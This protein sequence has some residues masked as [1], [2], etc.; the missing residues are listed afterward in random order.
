M[1][2]TSADG[3]DVA[4]IES[5]GLSLAALGG[6]LTHAYPPAFQ[7]RLL[8]ASQTH[9]P[10][11]T[12]EAD[13]TN[14]HIN[15]VEIFLQERGIAASSLDVVG[16]HGHTIKHNTGQRISWQIGSGQALAKALGVAVVGQ[17]RQADIAAGGQGAPLVPIYHQA[18]ARA[19]PKPVAI[20]NIG[21]VANVTWL[22]EDGAMLA[23]DTGTGNALINDRVRRETGQECDRDGILAKQGQVD[24]KLVNAWL[25]DAYFSRQPPKS[26]DRND[27]QRYVDDTASLTLPNAVA[28]LTAFSV[29]AIAAAARLFPKPVTQ[30]IVVGGGRHNPVMMTSL[31]TALAKRVVAGEDVGW[32]SDLIEAQAFAFLA[33]RHLCALPQTFPSTT[34]APHPLTGGTLFKP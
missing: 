16:F 30:W 25:C 11:P 1:S 10:D 12:L 23:F 29:R 24:E 31:A 6:G 21:G 19:L 20:V 7:E 27:F 3:I 34:G 8:K 9:S 14:A 5:D 15:A 4:Y 2:G 32:N 28:T 22:G 17:F 26:L 13:L 18:L 33:V